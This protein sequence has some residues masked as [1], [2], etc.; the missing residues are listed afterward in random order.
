MLKI[1]V[2]T[3]KNKNILFIEI[4]FKGKLFYLDK[5]LYKSEKKDFWAPRLGRGL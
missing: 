5:G 1:V 3:K 4:R 2:L